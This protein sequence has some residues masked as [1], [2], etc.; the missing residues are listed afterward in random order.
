[1]LQKV[2][3]TALG[4]TLAT[5][6]CGQSF[7][8][9]EKMGTKKRFEFQKG[10]IIGLQL[11]SDD[12]FSRVTIV[13]LRDSSIVTENLVIDFSN[14]KAVQLKEN[15]GFLKRSGPVL[16]FAGAALFAIDFINQAVVQGGGYEFTSGVA[17]ASASMIGVGA[18]FSLSGRDKVKMKRWWRLRIV[19][20]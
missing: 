5:V 14:I 10:E 9:L 17:I 15:P 12:F 13:D 16:M 2:L 7:L 19:S 11:D 18:A 4:V 20:I 8:V 1:M 3:M 6:V